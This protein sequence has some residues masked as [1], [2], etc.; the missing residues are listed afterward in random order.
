[1]YFHGDFL[2]QKIYYQSIYQSIKSMIML[3]FY[4]NR[5]AYDTH[6]GASLYDFFS[7]SS[8]SKALYNAI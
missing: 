4:R 5:K 3:K 6:T 7:V 8:L 2:A 1:M